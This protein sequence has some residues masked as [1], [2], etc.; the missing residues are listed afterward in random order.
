M[1]APIRGEAI[2]PARPA[3]GVATREHPSSFAKM[4]RFTPR[5]RR[6]STV[7]VSTGAM[8]VR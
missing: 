5:V 1:G 2:A 4:Y 3:R 7:S 8:T 6:P